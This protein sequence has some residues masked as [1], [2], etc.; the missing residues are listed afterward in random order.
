MT[1]AGRRAACRY[2]RRMT[3]SLRALMTGLIDYSGVFPPAALGMPEAVKNYATYLAGE[4]APV[5]KRFICR[6]SALPQLSEHGGIVM[7]GTYATS[8][9]TEM[10]GI[11][12][13]WSVSA[14]IDGELDKCLDLI[15]AFNERHESIDHGQARV[16]AIEMK[17]GEVGDID[18]ALDEIPSD[19]A[20]AFELPSAVVF[21]GDPRGFVAA[22]AGG[23]ACAKIR[24]GGVTP[25]LIPPTEGVAAVI[26]A[27]AIA[28]VAFKC[29][30][31]LHHPVRAE[32]RLTYDEHPPRAVMHGFFNVFV[33]AM[34]VRTRAI[35]PAE[36]VQVLEETDPSAFTFDD[37]G[38]AWRGNMVPTDRVAR[39]RESFCLGYGSCSFTE[40]IEDLR[41]LGLL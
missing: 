35:S 40:P 38:C 24:C 16:T 32:Q 28:E 23:E 17:I 9:Y 37:D 4:H 19:L 36:L 2:D 31:G 39:C 14:V 20:V 41:E 11:A 7:P 26:N 34:L 30:A 25:E 1:G 27:C 6:A 5:L 15:D 22:L 29:T 33:G 10:A 8:G 3:E 12:D 18:D 21:G 13:P